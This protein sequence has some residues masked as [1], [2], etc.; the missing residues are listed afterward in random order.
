MDIAQRREIVSRFLRRCVTYADASIERKK[1]RNEDPL[2]IS[3]WENYRQFT[4]FSASEVESGELD[5]LLE[6]G[7]YRAEPNGFF[8]LSESRES[9]NLED[10]SHEERRNWLA[11]LLMPRPIS[12][13]AT[14]SA[15]GV[16]NLAPMSSIGVVSN[17][18]PLITI[19]LSK[20]REG[21]ERDTLVNLRS[22]GI[23]TSCMIF[24]L[25]ATLE[26]A[27]NIQLTS[28]KIPADESEWNL[29]DEEMIIENEMPIL[30]SAM[31]A[32]RCK[33]M[34]IHPLPG[35]SLAS[36]AIL[37]VESV[38]SSNNYSGLNDI[39]KLMQ[40]DFN[41]LGPSSSKNDWNFEVDY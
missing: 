39:Q 25:P 7:D 32:L 2:D 18:P 21:K 5:T 9:F 31:A 10:M 4:S 30:S 20:S 37:Q 29:I 15:N 22:Q 41:K 36:L 11:C 14:M 16:H 1:S 35:G 26:S 3:N 12:L 28:S 8:S 33:L 34:E 19:S 38:I 13:V 17:S 24:I 40:V 27:K 23:G 6:E